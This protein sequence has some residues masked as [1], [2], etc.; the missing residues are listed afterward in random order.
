MAIGRGVSFGFF[1][2]FEVVVVVFIFGSV[3]VPISLN[4]NGSNVNGFASGFAN[5]EGTVGS[6]VDF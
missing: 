4:A 1:L 2:D 3:S 6:E 5:V